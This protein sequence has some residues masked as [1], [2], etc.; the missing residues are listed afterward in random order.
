[1]RVI[2]K[3][4][5]TSEVYT[6]YINVNMNLDMR[7]DVEISFKIDD[8]E[9]NRTFEYKHKNEVKRSTV[10]CNLSPKDIEDL[11]Q[12]NNRAG[13]LLKHEEVID[14]ITDLA[15]WQMQEVTDDEAVLD[16]IANDD[17]TMVVRIKNVKKSNEY[18]LSDSIENAYKECISVEELDVVDAIV[19][20]IKK[21]L[22]APIGLFG[23]EMKGRTNRIVIQGYSAK[24]EDAKL[25]RRLGGLCIYSKCYDVSYRDDEYLC[26]LVDG[27]DYKL[28]RYTG[29]ELRYKDIYE[30]FGTGS[31]R[32]IRKLIV[33][34]IIE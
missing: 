29:E 34:E 1:M 5:V 28:K 16:R 22:G 14:D 24:V 12:G 8:K 13:I 23:L 21:R 3:S 25:I 17:I 18:E 32:L 33:M 30:L 20:G 26:L 15:I 19:M 11:K 4:G 7:A 27:D 10:L 9:Y 31:D 2:E 6:D